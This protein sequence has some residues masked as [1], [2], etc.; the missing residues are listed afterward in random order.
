M[1]ISGWAIEYN[2]CV[3]CGTTEW[4]HAGRGLC[5]RCYRRQW[6]KKNPEYT[7]KYY[8]KNKDSIL[9]SSR[10]WHK[11]NP[12]Y[13]KKW[14]EEN[15]EELQRKQRIRRRSKT[16]QLHPW[17]AT[18]TWMVF[19]PHEKQC[20]K[21]LVIK[22]RTDFYRLKRS[23]DGL[24]SWCRECCKERSREYAS[25]PERRRKACEYAKKYRERHPNRRKE[26]R[27]RYKESHRDKIRADKALRKAI[28]RGAYGGEKITGEQLREI[29]DR[30]G[31]KCV[32]CD[33]EIELTIDHIVAIDSGGKHLLD[34]IALACLSC[35]SSKSNKDLLRWLFE[36]NNLD[37][38]EQRELL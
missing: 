1:R 31:N 18:L 21:C 33:E 23:F 29:A 34:N 15:K 14:Y 9:E 17:R 6:H 28:K 22:P 12:E 24:D 32:Y 3:S 4:P 36:N 10:R 16:K 7:K 38:L 30:Q 19:H 2:T 13:R 11:R 25:N 37:P 20:S 35:N 5:R 8:K 26:S 27:R